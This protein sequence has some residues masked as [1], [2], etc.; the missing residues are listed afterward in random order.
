MEGN[1]CADAEEVKTGEGW[2]AAMDI[3]EKAATSVLTASKN[4][5]LYFSLIPV[6]QLAGIAA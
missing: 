6:S 4:L 5:C 3:S 1:I 2:A